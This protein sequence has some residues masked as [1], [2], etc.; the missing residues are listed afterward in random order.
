MAP[1]LAFSAAL[2]GPGGLEGAEVT[3]SGQW[4]PPAVPRLLHATLAQKRARTAWLAVFRARAPLPSAALRG[5][6]GFPAALSSTPATMEAQA[7]GG[8]S[9]VAPEVW[10]SEAQRD[11]LPLPNFTPGQTGT[12]YADGTRSRRA[13]SGSRL[14][15]LPNSDFAVGLGTRE[16]MGTQKLSSRSSGDCVLVCTVLS[17]PAVCGPHFLNLEGAQ[18]TCCVGSGSLRCSPPPGGG[19]WG[20]GSWFLGIRALELTSRCSQVRRGPERGGSFVEIQC[21]CYTGAAAW[22]GGWPFNGKRA[23]QLPP[24]PLPR[25]RLQIDNPDLVFH[26]F[27]RK[28]GRWSY[29]GRETERTKTLRNP[30]WKRHSEGMGCINAIRTTFLPT[31]EFCGAF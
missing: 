18:R 9:P 28:D 21:P 23:S 4:W 17:L 10:S 6:R 19:R 22:G 31:E 26:P 5:V 8:W 1:N 11:S 24:L 7:Q 30:L 15:P 13:P 12:S 27:L 2:G 14:H 29:V 3:S 25:P 16:G 20:R